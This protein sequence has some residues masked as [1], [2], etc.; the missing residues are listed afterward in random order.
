MAR[1]EDTSRRMREIMEIRG[2]E[3][4]DFIQ[5]DKLSAE[6]NEK[7]LTKSRFYDVLNGKNQ[8][9]TIDMLQKFCDI[10]YWPLGEFYEDKEDAIG[11][12]LIETEMVRDIHSLPLRDIE[13][14][15]DMIRVRKARL[16][17]EKGNKAQN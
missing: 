2:L 4:V 11:F 9:P 3:P 16:V 5:S 7:R 12:V 1:I 6:E 15:K 17:K 13:F 10:A 14:V 8:N